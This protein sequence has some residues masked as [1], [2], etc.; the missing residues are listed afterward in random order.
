MTS[1]RWRLFALLL[2]ATV[3]VW[4]AAAAWIYV[5]TRSDV[6]RVLD[7]RLVE[8]AG[9]VGSLARNS[10]RTLQAAPDERTLPVETHVGRQL[11]CQIWT[12]DGRLVGRSGSAP[13]V[14]LSAGDNGFSERIINGE[15]WR[16]YTLVE[17]EA[18]LR[19][20]VGD[21]LKVRR[22]LTADVMAG[23]LLPALAGVIA[24]AVLLWSA[25]GRGLRPLQQVA[26]ELSKRDPGDTDALTVELPSRELRPLVDAING[27]FGRF[28]ELRA[29]ERHFIASA[30]H[31]LQTPLAGLKAHAQV[32]VAADDPILRD[33]SLRSIQL[34]VDRTSRLVEQLLDLAREEAVSLTT[35][36]GW[37]SLGT[38][39]RMVEDEMRIDLDRRAVRLELNPK[40]ASTEVRADEASLTL[41][42]RNLIRNAVEH[43]PEESRVLV[44][45][46][47]QGSSAAIRVLDEGPGI[48]TEEL[49]NIRERFV[50]GRRA[51]GPGSGLGLSIVELVGA[52]FG[53]VLRLANRPG[54]GLEASLE[55]PSEAIRATP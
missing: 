39:V 44:D 35:G 8:A 33:K 22:N 20:L 50:R 21:N 25:V 16:V 31:E 47:D 54:G 15:E 9:M 27:L 4:S 37:S 41:A 19:I 46:A 53:A 55:L 48:P 17:P 18:G 5:S 45:V 14:P 38:V 51:K 32:A 34:S 6:Q 52:R 40:A 11:S 1:I 13:S 7:N 10:A 30:A 29:T 12:L 26:D 3:L 43:A 2:S 42:L 28:E 49:P 23:L 24:L 36:A